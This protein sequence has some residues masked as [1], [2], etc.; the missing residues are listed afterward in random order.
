MFGAMSPSEISSLLSVLALGAI[1]LLAFGG[2]VAV[3]MP[4]LTEPLE[5]KD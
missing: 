5:K 2:G 1:G 3:I 4:T